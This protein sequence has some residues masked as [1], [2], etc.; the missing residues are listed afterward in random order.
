MEYAKNIYNN[1]E[2]Y[3]FDKVIRLFP[4]FFMRIQ[5]Y[6]NQIKSKE[7]FTEYSKIQ[8]YAAIPLKLAV[9]RLVATTKL[10]EDV[11]QTAMDALD[12]LYEADISD[13]KYDEYRQELCT[14]IKSHL[15]N[16]ITQDS[17]NILEVDKLM[18]NLQ[19]SK[20]RDVKL[21]NDYMRIAKSVKNICSTRIT[22]YQN[23]IDIVDNFGNI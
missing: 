22:N 18:N 19:T 23:F 14:A 5:H 15:N 11:S 21:I 17:L 4:R 9:N 2:G 7:L 1:V 16:M 8:S 13:D 10:D 6:Y 12:S 20:I 3:S